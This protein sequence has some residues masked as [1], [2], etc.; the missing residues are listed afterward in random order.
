LE[1]SYFGGKERVKRGLLE[2]T[3]TTEAGDVTIFGVHLK[4]R[5][6]DRPDD[7][8]SAQ[9]RV[10]EATAVR[11]CVLQRVGDPATTRFLILGDCNDT[12]DSKAVQRLLKRGKTE[13]ATLVPASDTRGD[14]WTHAYRKEDSYSRVDHIL[15]SAALKPVV[16]NG[17]AHIYDGPHVREASDHRPVSVTL[18]LAG[19]QTSEGKSPTPQP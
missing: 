18:E 3:I 10:A 17:V 7:P 4:S 15:V 11:D 1:F 16:R 12:K 5:F 19:W 13:I 9:R 2:V 6:T 8:M 14:S